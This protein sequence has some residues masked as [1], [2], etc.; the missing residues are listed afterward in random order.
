MKEEEVN[1]AVKKWLE[2][3][4]YTYK[5]VAKEKGK[6][7]SGDV[8]VPN[9]KRDVLID[10]QGTRLVDEEGNIV[11]FLDERYYKTDKKTDKLHFE[12]IWIEGKGDDVGFSEILEGF[13]R[14][15]YAVFYG[16]GIGLLATG[17]ERFE[18]IMEEKSFFESVAK[19]T[20]GKGKVGVMNTETEEV[21]IF[22]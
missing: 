22:D 15:V 21:D 11:S 17:R 7:G 6:Y 14:V 4:G 2:K 16:G 19:V 20:I 1:K 8:P 3:N 5:G 18:K 13:I 12:V 10:N 9:G